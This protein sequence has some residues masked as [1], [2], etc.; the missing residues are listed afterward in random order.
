MKHLESLLEDV[1]KEDK[2]KKKD[3]NRRYIV[4]E[5]I[6]QVALVANAH[7]GKA[8]ALSSSVPKEAAP[9]LLPAEEAGSLLQSLE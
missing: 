5:A 2:C 3:L 1:L 9:V 4:V 6:Y 7:L 8:R